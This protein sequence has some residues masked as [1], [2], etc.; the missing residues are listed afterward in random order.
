MTIIFIVSEI[1]R[2]LTSAPWNYKIPEDILPGPGP[3]LIELVSE[4]PAL[5]VTLSVHTALADCRYWDE[6]SQE[7]K[8]HGCNVSICSTCN[9]RLQYSIIIV[10]SMTCTRVKLWSSIFYDH[11]FFFDNILKVQ[12]FW[13]NLTK[14]HF[15]LCVTQLDITFQVSWR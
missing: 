5:I 15:L 1:I 4:A 12:S 6:I 7:W 2:P 10:I 11:Q 13:Y 8:H 14:W 9:N 3:Y